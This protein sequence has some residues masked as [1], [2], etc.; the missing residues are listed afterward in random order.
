MNKSY[1][2]RQNGILSSRKHHGSFEMAFCSTKSVFFQMSFCRR[3]RG[4]SWKHDGADSVRR[5]S[6]QFAE[7]GL[8]E[9]GHDIG[10]ATDEQHSSSDGRCPKPER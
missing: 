8:T 3:D 5:S 4:I 6:Q 9:A 10:Y 1:N 7:R 2:F